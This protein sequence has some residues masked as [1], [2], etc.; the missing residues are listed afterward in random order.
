MFPRRADGRD[1]RLTGKPHGCASAAP[2]CTFVQAAPLPPSTLFF[3]VTAVQAPGV[4]RTGSMRHKACSRTRCAFSTSMRRQ[5][6]SKSLASLASSWRLIVAKTSS[7]ILVSAVRTRPG[8]SKRRI[9]SSSCRQ[10]A[11]SIS[12]FRH[13][14]C[15][16][17]PSRRET[18]FRASTR[19]LRTSSSSSA[20]GSR[21]I[22]AM[23]R[24]RSTPGSVMCH[25]RHS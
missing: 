22:P 19:R 18:V 20:T 9:V 3:F 21:R 12:F 4:R 7:T 25:R 11:Y 5:T 16:S 14:S 15:L 23:S 2:G 17:T 13:V 24:T 1:R 6:S 8:A 10:L